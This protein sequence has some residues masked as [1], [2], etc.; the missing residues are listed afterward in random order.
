M[1]ESYLI[2]LHTTR[3][4]DDEAVSITGIIGG[5]VG[6]DGNGETS[7]NRRDRSGASWVGGEVTRNTFNELRD[8]YWEPQATDAYSV[9]FRIRGDRSV[10]EDET[11]RI[12]DE[13]VK[14]RPDTPMLLTHNLDLMDAS[15]LPGRGVKHFPGGV[16]IYA[17]AEPV[18]RK[19]PVRQGEDEFQ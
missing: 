9:Y 4:P 19:W 1:P 17:E 12:F 6:E 7:V 15:Y 5:E 3:Q 8:E 13:L 16:S 14:G 11:A 2:Y 10:L 18:W